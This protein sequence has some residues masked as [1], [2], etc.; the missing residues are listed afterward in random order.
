MHTE[1]SDEE[2]LSAAEAWIDDLARGD[3]AAAFARTSHDPYYRW[4]PE[5]IE[6]VINGYGL[7]EPHRSGKK[8]IVTPRSD[9]KGRPR[10]REVDR[11]VARDLT[12]AEVWYDL[13]LNGE[14]SDLTATFRVERDDLHLSLVLEEIH[15]F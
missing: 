4:T 7:P 6:S 3:Y 13:P 1:A 10:N 9:A 11:E 14:W 8:F 12:V 15:V 2:I 5:L